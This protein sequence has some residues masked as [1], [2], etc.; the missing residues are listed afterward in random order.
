ILV[1]AMRE[2]AIVT[3]G[4]LRDGA[5]PRATTAPARFQDDAN[6]GCLQP[7]AFG[8]LREIR[9]GDCDEGRWVIA[10]HCWKITR[11]LCGFVQH[12]EPFAVCC[13]DATSND[14]R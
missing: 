3:I 14:M 12:P 7:P 1:V 2:V 5:L 11:N 13:H 10:S 9:I 4:A 6:I 8:C